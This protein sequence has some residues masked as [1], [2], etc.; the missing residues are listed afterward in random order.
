MHGTLGGNEKKRAGIYERERGCIV[1]G[2]W[3][4]KKR[5]LVKLNEWFHM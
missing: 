3:E 5:L 1:A 4:K 2:G